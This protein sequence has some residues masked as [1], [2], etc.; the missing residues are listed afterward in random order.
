M[1]PEQ[2]LRRVP[3]RGDGSGR[4]WLLLIPLF[5]LFLLNVGLGYLT[6]WA[7]YD[8]LGYSSVLVTRIVASLGLFVVGFVV[9]WLF[10]AIN[11]WIARR[12]EP[13]GLTNTPPE[14]IAA[15]FGVRAPVVLLLAAAVFSFFMGAG[16]SNDWQ[17]LLLYLNQ[18]PFDVSDPLWGLDVSFFMFTLPA[19]DIARGWLLLVVLA[20]LV[21]AVITAGVGWRGWAV[22]SRVLVQL[23]VLGALALALI[24]VQYRIDAYQL[25]YSVRGSFVGAGYTDVHAQLPAFNLLAILTLAAALLLIALAVLRRGGRTIMAVLG[26][27]VVTAI[28]AGV[29]YPA[30]VQRFQVAPNELNLEGPYIADNIEFTRAAFGL[31]EV[32]SEQYNATRQL[33]TEAILAEPETI[34]SIRL[35]DYR[36]LL[37]TYNQVQALRQY[38]EF[39]DVDVDRYDVDGIRQQVMVAAR[40]LVPD[41]LTADAQTWV[42]RKLVY[43]HGYGVAMSPV[44]QVT[45]DGLPEFFLKDLPVTGVMSVTQPQIY[46]GELTGDYVIG[47]TSEA[48]FDYPQEAGNMTHNF[49]ADTGIAMSFWNR[50][51]FAIRFADI[52]MILNDDIQPDSQLLWRRDIEERVQLLAPFL[53]YDDDPY[54]VVGDDGRLYWFIDAYTTSDRYPYSDSFRG[55]INYMRNPVKVVINAYDGATTFYVVDEQEPIA[56][57]YRKIFPA[58]FRPL[59][60]LPE[61]LLRHVR[62][63]ADLFTVQAQMYRTYHMTNVTDFYNREDVWAWPEEIFYNEPQPIEPYYVLMQLPGSSELDYMQILP[64]TPA[65][66]ENMVSWLAAQSDP[67]K[68]GERIVYKFGRDTLFFGPK[69]I[70]ARIDQDPVISAQLSLWNSQGS[71]VIRGNLLVIPMGESLLYVEPLYLQAASGRIPELKRVVVATADRVVMAENLGLALIR[72]FGRD[73][74]NQAGL[75]DL[76]VTPVIDAL[77]VE[78]AAPGAPAAPAPAAPELDLASASLEELVGAANDYY[79]RGQVR[80]RDGDWAGYGAE[81]EALQTVLNQLATLTGTAD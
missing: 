3:E 37:Q 80:L 33:T 8:S 11:L 21:A 53:Q 41:R 31:D 48:E 43:T 73:V 70:E 32:V 38:Y 12:L 60:E 56:A 42:N 76:A 68:Y 45:A 64:F 6:D 67:E 52:N 39:H 58:L 24:A 25:V 36:P 1:P 34:R 66:R 18:I 16:L 13:S 55:A 81:M 30:F 54:I 78:D 15:A 50:V 46:F 72:L 29:A 61:G 47:R 40:E 19:W 22:R 9:S 10:I 7:W 14:Q 4:L 69:Q 49:S 35:W 27:W 28:L 17:Q 71:G 20:A 26:I 5:L 75:A 2:E 77:A 62:Y 59:S 44:A 65:N 57:A 79:M 63:P 74:V 51:L 23:A